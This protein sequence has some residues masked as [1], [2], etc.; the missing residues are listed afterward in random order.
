MIG[1]TYFAHCYAHHQELMTIVLI[2]TLF[3]IAESI[4][5]IIAVYIVWFLY[6]SHFYIQS[7]LKLK[8]K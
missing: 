4:V 7:V 2:T 5:C 1:S 8:K 6:Y 3:F